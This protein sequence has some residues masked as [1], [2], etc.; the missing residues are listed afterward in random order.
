MKKQN[1]GQ[2]TQTK[3][4]QRQHLGVE[5]DVFFSSETKPADQETDQ[6]AVDF[7]PTALYPIPHNT[8]KDNKTP[9]ITS[10]SNL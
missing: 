5:T 8:L 1:T 3:T 6:E 7:N 9:N 2:N 4:R 10:A